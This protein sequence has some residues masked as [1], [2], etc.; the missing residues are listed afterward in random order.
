M[1]LRAGDWVEIRSKEEILQTLD[2]NGRLENMPFTPQMFQYCGQKFEVY[3]RAHKSCDTVNTNPSGRR[4]PNA[5]H[6]EIRCDGKAYGGCQTACPLFWKEAWLKPVSDATGGVGSASA[7]SQHKPT[8]ETACTEEIVQNATWG[9]D[10]G[11]ADGKRYFCQATEMLTY[12]TFLP[13]WDLKQYVEDY[14]SRNST[15]RRLFKGFAYGN[16]HV[17]ARKHKFGFGT[18]FRW[19]YD[20]FQGL[21]GGVPYPDR[22]GPIPDDQP[23]PLATLNL[24]PGELV[25]VKPYKEILATLNTKLKNRGM[26]FDADQVPYCG[27]V[28]RVKAR[29][30]RFL[31]EKTGRIMSLKTPAVILEGVWCQACYSRLRLGCPRALHSWWREIWLERVP[32]GTPVDGRRFDTRRVG[33][34]HS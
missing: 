30:E 11:S 9:P 32:E 18:P 4:L 5:V 21:I 19:L 14:T 26:V 12:S 33:K 1:V 24:Q 27:R 3:K 2:K 31:N 16:Y 7:G 22:R 29:V 20:T 17:L 23:T 34:N 8:N 25:R 28:Y 15:L 6:L 10:P 13:W